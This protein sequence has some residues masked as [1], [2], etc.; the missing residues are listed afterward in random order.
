MRAIT[1]QGW[2]TADLP[3]YIAQRYSSIPTCINSDAW[4]SEWEGVG[5]TCKGRKT[6]DITTLLRELRL[7][8]KLLIELAGHSAPLPEYVSSNT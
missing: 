8:S 1:D 5:R 2:A 7:A 4:N 6:R 3:E